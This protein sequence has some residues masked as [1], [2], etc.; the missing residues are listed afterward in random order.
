MKQ[1]T[2]R[3][4]AHSRDWKMSQATALGAESPPGTLNC[5]E[6]NKKSMKGEENYD[7]K[8]TKNHVRELF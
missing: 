4:G 1:K 3:V 7:S 2:L 5:I 6:E 8:R